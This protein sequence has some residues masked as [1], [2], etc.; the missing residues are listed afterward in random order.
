MLASVITFLLSQVSC[1][2]INTLDNS[3][4]H[5]VSGFSDLIN[6][7]NFLIQVLNIHNHFIKL[8]LSK[9]VDLFVGFDSKLFIRILFSLQNSK[10]LYLRCN[11]IECL[12]LF[13]VEFSLTGVSATELEDVK[14]VVVRKVFVQRELHVLYPVFSLKFV[15][16][17]FLIVL[18]EVSIGVV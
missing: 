9:L 18:E 16:H 3:F 4:A 15:S 13:N 17:L 1:P 8:F 12:Y 7:L 11:L 10:I 6:Q 2:A 5:Y 14:E